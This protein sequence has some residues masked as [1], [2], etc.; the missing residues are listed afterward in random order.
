MG[1]LTAKPLRS[2]CVSV[3]VVINILSECKDEQSS[4]FLSVLT[5][6]PNR[7]PGSGFLLLADPNSGSLNGLDSIAFHYSVYRSFQR[8]LGLDGNLQVGYDIP[9]NFV[10]SWNTPFIQ[11]DFINA[12]TGEIDPR[13]PYGMSNFNILRWDGLVNGM[14]RG[15]LGTFIGSL[16]LPGAPLVSFPPLLS[17]Q[18]VN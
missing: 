10:D 3:V 17:V 5:G 12:F 7:Y 8:F 1:K 16:L 6:L 13:H 4:V 14:R 11:T 9:V 18:V 15:A 2:A